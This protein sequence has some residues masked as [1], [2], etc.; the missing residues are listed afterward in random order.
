M[1]TTV[2][3]PNLLSRSGF[4][5]PVGDETPGSNVWGG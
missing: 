4:N 1:T 3:V 2:R 5:P